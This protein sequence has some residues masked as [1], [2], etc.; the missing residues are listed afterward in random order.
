VNSR[1][2]DRLACSGLHYRQVHH[3]PTLTSRDRALFRGEPIKISGK[4]LVLKA[5]DRLVLLVIG[6]SC[7][8][9]SKRLRKTMSVRIVRFANRDELLELTDLVPGSVPPFGRTFLE[10]DLAVATSVLSN[11]RI[12]FNVGS[13]TQSVVMSTRDWK[14]VAHRL[15][16]IAVGVEP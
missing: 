1:I 2:L 8:I 7:R 5:G 3:E 6:A 10:I 16:F 9:D 14:S 11:E 4:A 13:L 15:E 12:A